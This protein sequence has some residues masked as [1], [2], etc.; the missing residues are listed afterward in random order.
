LCYLLDAYLKRF[1]SLRDYLGAKVF[2]N[3]LDIAGIIYTKMSEV[4]T[5]IEKENIISLDRWIEFRNVRNELEYDYPDVLEEALN[6]LKYCVDN[7]YY[8][9]TIVKKVFEFSSKYD[10]N[11][12]LS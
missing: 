10:E 3:L 6:G 2:K 9:E 1:A 11:I 7:V 5:L 12:K 4:L 8:M